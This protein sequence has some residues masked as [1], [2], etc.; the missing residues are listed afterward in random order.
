MKHYRTHVTNTKYAVDN[1]ICLNFRKN[2]ENKNI[3]ALFSVVDMLVPFKSQSFN[4]P[5]QTLF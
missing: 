1:Y 3:D 5:Y 2:E 4:P